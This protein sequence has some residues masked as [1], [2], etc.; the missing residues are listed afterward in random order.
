[1]DAIVVLD[2]TAADRFRRSL[3]NKGKIQL[4]DGEWVDNPDVG[5]NEPQVPSTPRVAPALQSRLPGGTFVSGSRNLG[6]TDGWEGKVFM[7]TDQPVMVL[8]MI[9]PWATAFK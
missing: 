5:A 8:S 4:D 9:L 1:M 6:A 2:P 7:S 3:E